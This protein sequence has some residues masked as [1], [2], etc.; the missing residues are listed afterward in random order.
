MMSGA[1]LEREDQNMAAEFVVKDVQLIRAEVKLVKCLV[2]NIVVDIS[3]NQLGGLST[4]CFLE[5]VDCLIGKDHLFKRILY[6][7]HLF[8]Y[9]FEWSS[10]VLYKFLDYFSNLIG[11]TILRCQINGGGDLLLSNDFLRKNN[12]LGRSVEKTFNRI[13]SAFT[14]GMEVDRGPDVQDPIPLSRYDGFGLGVQSCKKIM[15]FMNPNLLIQ[16]AWVGESGLNHERSRDGG[17]TNIN[18]PG[19]VM[20]DHLKVIQSYPKNVPGN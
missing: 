18:V 15:Q 8:P 19:Q 12:N 2:Q 11:T 13:R 1:I 5:Q 14:Y 10:S 7:F 20:N 17:V 4:L 6:I 16:Q 3:F 9:I